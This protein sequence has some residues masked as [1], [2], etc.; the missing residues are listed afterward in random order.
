MPKR[1]EMTIGVRKRK[2]LTKAQY[3]KMERAADT[4]NEFLDGEICAMTGASRQHN[5]ITVNATVAL[6]PQITQRLC[7]IYTNDLRVKVSATGAYAYPDIAVVCGAQFEDGEV[8]TLLNPI[9]IIEVL[10][11]STAARDHGE[12]FENYRKLDSLMEYLLVSQ[13]RCHVEHFLR[14]P[15]DKWLLTEYNDLKDIIE[16][17]SIGCHLSLSVI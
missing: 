2:K 16:L 6:Y 8:D 1:C 10:S 13:S 3:L 14:Q 5:T 7:E 4:K 12:K 11:K 17:P 15:D 9:V